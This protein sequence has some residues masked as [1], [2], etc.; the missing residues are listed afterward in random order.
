MAT[1]TMMQVLGEVLGGK[2]AK[3]TELF[4]KKG[5]VSEEYDTLEKLESL[6][7]KLNKTVF[8]GTAENGLDTLAEISA[9]LAEN[10]DNI[11]AAKNTL[12][13]ADLVDNLTTA[14]QSKALAASQGKQLKEMVDTLS[15]AVNECL[16]D[17]NSYTDTQLQNISQTLTQLT[18]SLKEKAN[19]NEV[20]TKT[21]VGSTEEFTA[22][23][24][25]ACGDNFKA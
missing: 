20:Y 12:S 5:N 17:A 22:S 21:E 24:E 15:L 13:T 14:D 4:A 16:T 8:E 19:S 7:K 23:F 11:L 10:K 18:N 2:F 3:I 1:K 25:N 6:I 9:F